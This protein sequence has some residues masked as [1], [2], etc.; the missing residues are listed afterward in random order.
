MRDEVE[1][2][3]AAFDGQRHAVEEYRVAT[4]PFYLPVGDE[5]ALFEAAWRERIPVLLK[6]PTGCGKTRFIEHMSWRLA[7]GIPAN[8]DA[9]EADATGAATAPACRS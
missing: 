7:Q 9:D 8:A 3:R 2:A 1:R 4:E 6:G 5:I